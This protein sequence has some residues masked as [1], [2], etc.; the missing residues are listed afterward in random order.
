MF[1]EDGKSRAEITE[2]GAYVKSLKLSGSEILKPSEDGEQTHGGMAILLPFANRV[3]NAKYLWEGEEYYLPQN[4]GDHS[5]HGFTRDMKWDLKKAAENKVVGTLDMTNSGYPVDLRLK[6]TFL[7]S[8]HAFTTSIEAINMGKVTAPFVAGM[9]PYF[10]FNGSWHLESFQNLLRLNYESEYFPDGSLTPVK[11]KCLNSETGITFDNTYITN[12][13]PTLVAGDRKIRIET[14]NMPYLVL[15]N[16]KYAGKISVAAEP[17]SG[18]PDAYNNGIG[19]AT[20]QP[21]DS[22]QCSATFRTISVA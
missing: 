12:S 14:S 3:R 20:I 5:I 19:L 1:I 21:G 9:H 10:N 11:P 2:K 15:Y 18:A 13:I 16:G 6:V 7:I 22:F 17:M 4:N 8:A